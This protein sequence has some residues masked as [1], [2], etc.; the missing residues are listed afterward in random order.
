M[1]TVKLSLLLTLLHLLTIPAAR[2]VDGVIDVGIFGVIKEQTFVQE[3][4]KIAKLIEPDQ[5]NAPIVFNVFMDLNSGGSISSATVTPPVGATVSLQ[6]SGGSYEFSYAA[7]HLLDLNVN[8]PNG[9]YTVDIITTH[10]GT[11]QQTLTLNGDTYPNVP[12][13]SNFG[14]AQAITAAASFNLTWDAFTGGT[15]S[16]FIQVSVLDDNGNE[17]WSS[18]SP[19]SGLDG[20]AT[21]VTIPANTL[22]AG[23][24]YQA[25]IMF[26]KIVD[27]ADLSGTTKVA[28]YTKRTRLKIGTSGTPTETG[29]PSLAFPKPYDGELSVPVNS[30]IAFNF[31]EPM[32]RVDSIT[33]TGSGLTP[34]NF[35]YTWSYDDR[36]LY[37]VYNQ[38]LPAGTQISWTLNPVGGGSTMEDKAGNDLP[39]ATGSFTTSNS[40]ATS[41]PDVRNIFLIKSQGLLQTNATPVALDR[42]EFEVNGDLFVL[43]GIL[44]GSVT[45]PSGGEVRPEND[46]YGTT[47][48]FS[49]EYASK[50]D[51]DR[52]FPSDGAYNI[53]LATAHNGPQN[54]ALTYP[55]DNYPNDPTLNNFSNLQ[56]ID[57]TLGLTVSWQS[58]TGADAS[59]TYFIQVNLE[60]DSGEEV[61]SS[62]EPGAPGALA[63]NALSVDIPANTLSPG[64]KYRGELVFA[65][66]VATDASTYSG[67]SLAAIFAKVTK[68]SAQTTG[69]PIQATLTFSAGNPPRIDVTGD[70]HVSYVLEATQDFQSW[71]AVSYPQGTYNGTTTSLFDSDAT[72]FSR[73]FYRVKEVPSNNYVPKPVSLQGRVVDLSNSNPVAGATVSTTLSSTTAVTDSNGN[74]F[75]QTDVTLADSY[76]SYGVTVTKTGYQTFS[77]NTVWGETA[78]N[79]QI[80]LNPNP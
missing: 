72:F 58:F 1:K 13:V 34:A 2:A 49:A 67:V 57:P 3:S 65:R 7:A 44:N 71:F 50:T 32:T 56:A 22:V 27:F 53:S 15:A 60:T 30:V 76:Q 38:S 45:T 6:S 62:P 69:S 31:S 12:R 46:S 63:G 54:I 43:N 47:F 75:L 73:R 14:A 29:A 52:F 64:R 68:F 11:I 55:A 35:T 77:Q 33:W 51:L 24:R 78:R 18:G 39:L 25:E 19:G 10:N 21:Q 9:T 28:A 80:A 4:D 37:A 61:Y 23:T 5:N 8:Y 36:I 26:A 59:S 20:T 79:L 42:Y 74:F 16:D 70:K 41:D 17:L 66:I 48:D 40:A